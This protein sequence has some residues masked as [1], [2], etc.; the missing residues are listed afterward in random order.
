MNSPSRH[1]LARHSPLG[2]EGRDE[3]DDDDQP[4]IGHQLRHF[5]DAADV[6]DAVLVGEA[7]VAVEPV[8]DIVA[9]EDVGVAA[10]RVQLLFQ[11]VGD[12]R[13]AGARQAGE[14]EHRRP[15]VL[16]AA[17]APS[18][19]RRATASGC[20]RRAAA[21]C[22]IMPAPT[23][24]LVTRSIRMK[25][26]VARFSAKVSKAIGACTRDVADADLV[27][28]QRLG[29]LAGEIVDVDAVLQLGDRGARLVG[30]GAQQVGAAGQQRAARRTRRGWRRTGR[31]HA[32]APSA[33]PACCRARSRPRRRAPASPPGRRRRSAGRR[34]G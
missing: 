6:L 1:Q 24:A 16:G 25:A 9:V 15:L 18:C 22:T 31:R 28:L 21:R 8:A 17:R 20:C 10:R 5:G 26:P 23:V 11:Q 14:P 13:L 29:R 34:P 30:L 3:G 2:P 27:H 7:E 12:G 32:A 33:R 4:G 19:R